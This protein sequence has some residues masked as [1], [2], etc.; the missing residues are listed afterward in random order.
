ML[1]TEINSNNHPVRTVNWFALICA[2]HIA[3]ALVGNYVLISDEMYFD[4]FGEQL[5]YDRVAQL[6][7]TS[8]EWLWIG[9]AILPLL[10]LLK[11]FL[12]ASC[13]TI[14]ALLLG[15]LA[16]FKSLF[17][18]AILS[19]LVLF[20]PSIIK[21]FWFGVFHVDYTL[22]DL[23][24]FSPLS[25]L[26]L[27]DRGSVEPWLLYP[28]QLLNVFELAYWLV[29]AYGLYELTGERYSKMLGLVAASYGTGLLLWVVFVVFLTINLTV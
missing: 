29:L 20:T 8:N 23:Q 16:T 22:Q 13:L 25:V 18:I 28:L 1:V 4:L 27:V 6:I 17:R 24:F 26:S 2:L 7:E 19:E 9:Y 3:F 15:T 21:I 5:A 10:L 14:G 11:F 12:V